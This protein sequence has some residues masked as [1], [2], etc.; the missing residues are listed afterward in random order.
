MR[1]LDPRF[2]YVPSMR[3]DV[4]ATWRR[5]GFRPTTESERRA[6]R[7]GESAPDSADLPTVAAATGSIDLGSA[8]SP[9]RSARKPSLKLAVGE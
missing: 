2:T 7:L 6:R 1:L 9:L 8:C 4:S 3:T 5:F